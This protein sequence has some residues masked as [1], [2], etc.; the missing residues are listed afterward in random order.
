MGMKYRKCDLCKDRKRYDRDAHRRFNSLS[1]EAK[2]NIKPGKGR[3]HSYSTWRDIGI[4]T[5]LKPNGE[6][7]TYHI[8]YCLACVNNI[9]D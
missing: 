5:V 4:Q 9:K 6:K 7:Q 2:T 1:E 8:K 3:S